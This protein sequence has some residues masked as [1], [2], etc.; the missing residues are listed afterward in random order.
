MKQ[1]T[2]AG[3]TGCS[4][5]YVGERLNNLSRYLQGRRTVIITDDNVAEFYGRDF[6]EADVIRIGTGEKIKT[7][8]TLAGIYQQLI[9]LEADRSIFLM[10]IG[11][12]IV[13]DITG[14]AASTYLRG[15]AFGYAP[16][17]LLAQVD[18]SVGG[19]T[20]V[21]FMGYKNMV[22]VFN[23]PAFVICDPL[24]LKTLPPREL[25]SGFAEIVKHAAIC[26]AAYFDRLEHAA[27]RAMALESD[28]LEEIIHDSVA[29][30]AA[31]VNRDETEKGERRKLNFG[32]TVGH[33]VEKTSRIS[34]GEAVSIGMMAAARLSHYRKM[35]KQAEVDR[36]RRLLERFRLPTEVE[37]GIEQNIANDR[38][39][40][41][42][43][44]VRDKKRAGDGIHFVLLE[45][46]GRAVVEKIAISELDQVFFW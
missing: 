44:L 33:A 21:N 9:T 42:D 43:A 27:D 7:L 31:I 2:I 18:A 32:H 25:S 46:I 26:D 38:D 19:K 4:D 12:G 14:F 39:S 16:T 13:C 11:G 30:K 41:L 6:P 17:T 28:V 10:G 40:L 8:E 1:I 5:I 34:H 3:H 15:V 23:Q 24:V 37:K 20:G 36:L 35:L 22:G 29:I 45:K